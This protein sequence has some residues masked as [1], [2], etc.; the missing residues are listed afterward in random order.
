MMYSFVAIPSLLLGVL[1]L[2]N[3]AVAFAQPSLS[4]TGISNAV[5]LTFQGS[6]GVTNQ[7]Q[8]LDTI[9]L[10]NWNVLTNFVPASNQ[11]ITTTD[12]SITSASARFYR[13]ALIPPSGTNS[14]PTVLLDNLTGSSD[15]DGLNIDTHQHLAVGFSLEAP[16]AGSWSFAL[17]I[18]S[19]GPSTSTLDLRLVDNHFNTTNMTDEP[20]TNSALVLSSGSFAPETG[21]YTVSASGPLPA[22]K[23]WLTAAS[24]SAL[25][26]YTW[27]D[28]GSYTES[29]ATLLGVRTDLG[30][31]FGWQVVDT[32]GAFGHPLSLKLEFTPAQ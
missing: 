8:W 28:R 29:G 15:R 24:T 3:A 16:L 25:D 9:G 4:I 7:V 27:I 30:D 32:A 10:T 5:E 17:R 12:S 1:T 23:Y 26:F 11:L 2:L 13:V 18:E 21:I 14:S 20:G 6:A 19:G 22:G 31:G